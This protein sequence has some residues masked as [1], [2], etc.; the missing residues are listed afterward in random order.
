MRSGERVIAHVKH[1]TARIQNQVH[2]VGT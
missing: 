1:L 2:S